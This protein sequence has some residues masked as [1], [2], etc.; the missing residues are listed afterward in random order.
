MKKQEKHDFAE[1]KTPY[2]RPGRGGRK[3]LPCPV[4]RKCGFFFDNILQNF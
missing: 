3:K 1:R 2:F 4:C